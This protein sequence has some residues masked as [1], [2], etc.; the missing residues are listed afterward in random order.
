MRCAALGRRAGS[1]GHPLTPVCDISMP[2]F[3]SGTAAAAA[4]AA[5]PRCAVLAAV[6]DGAPRA[7]EVCMAVVSIG[8]DTAAA[9]GEAEEPVSHDALRSELAADCGGGGQPCSLCEVE[10]LMRA[11][12]LS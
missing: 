9:A 11:D 4:A 10:S 3:D 1:D 7:N 2:P 12:Y 5:E 8:L 6:C